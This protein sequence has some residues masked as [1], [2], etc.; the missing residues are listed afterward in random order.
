MAKR[1]MILIASNDPIGLESA[2]AMLRD[3]GCRMLEADNGETALRL[4]HVHRPDLVVLDLNLPAIDGLTVCK[5]IREQ[6]EQTPILLLT[7]REDLVDIV[8][9]MSRGGSDYL[10]KPFAPDELA[11]R[12]NVLLERLVRAESMEWIRYGD[13]II[14]PE[15]AETSCRGRP[16]PFL[17]KEL[18]LFLFLALRPKRIF[19]AEHLYEMLWGH[20]DGDLRTVMVHIS[21]IRK[22][23]AWYAPDTVHIET[24]KGMGYR[25]VPLEPEA[26]D[27]RDATAKDAIIEAASQLFGEFGYEGMTMKEIAGR[28]G[29]HPSAIYQYFENKEDLFVHIYRNVLSGHLQIAALTNDTQLSAKANLEG[30]L[31]SVIEYQVREASKMK[32]YIRVLLFPT[33]YFEQDMKAEMNKLERMEWEWFTAVFRTG[34]E[35]GEVRRGD[36]EQ[37]ANLLITMMDGFFWKMQR[38]EADEFLDRFEAVWGQFWQFVRA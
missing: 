36:P 2:S 30:M 29:I 21:N 38:T 3:K 28:V 26:N 18:K 14:H 37:F 5:Q 33:G 20:S 13:L 12:V 23:L 27:R 24:I 9:G 10:T 31:R 35:S 22:K 32:I 15:T 7:G 25:L 16:I 6:S 8:E 4:Y 11:R 34:M 17:A 19:S 1:R